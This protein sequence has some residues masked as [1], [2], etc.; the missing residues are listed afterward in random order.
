MTDRSGRS[1]LDTIAS[2]Y[3]REGLH[4]LGTHAAFPDG[5]ISTEAGILEMQERMATGRF[6]VKAHLADWLDEYRSYHRD[7]DGQIVRGAG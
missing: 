6:R 3:R 1:F 7:K 2:H 4:M 5:S